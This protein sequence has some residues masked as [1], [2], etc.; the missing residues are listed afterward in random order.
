MTPALEVEAAAA[1][2]ALTEAFLLLGLPFAPIR[3]PPVHT[4]DEARQ[5]RANTPLADAVHTKNLFLPDKKERMWLLT[6]REDQ[7]VNLRALGA[8]LGSSG[9]P[10][11]GSADRLRAWLGV[12]PGSV[13]PLAVINDVRGGVKLL[14]DRSL[15]GARLAVHPNHN[16]ATVIVSYDGLV[17]LVAGWGHPPELIALEGSAP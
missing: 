5:V 9:N 17:R 6:L 8:R 3:H 11:F 1:E 16:A 12:T 15:V 4:V 10:S 14:L 2:A 7:E 13:T